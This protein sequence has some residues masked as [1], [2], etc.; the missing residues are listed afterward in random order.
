MKNKILIKLIVPSLMNEYDIFIPV[1]ERISKIKKLILN[2]LND[3]TDNK[4]DKS[5]KYNLIDPNTGI[6][7]SDDLIIRD[8]NIKN[9][10]RIIFY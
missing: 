10:S 6:E 2:S 9:S 5:K 4:I 1:N 8:L 3:L 7:Y